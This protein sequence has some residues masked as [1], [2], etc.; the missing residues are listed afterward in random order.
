MNFDKR[1]IHMELEN[2]FNVNKLPERKSS[3]EA[4]GLR[5]LL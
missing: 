5:S 1:I 4:Q 3:K 2:S